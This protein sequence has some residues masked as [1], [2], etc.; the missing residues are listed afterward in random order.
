MMRLMVNQMY[1][2]SESSAR[3]SSTVRKTG[4]DA[5]RTNDPARVN[6]AGVWLMTLA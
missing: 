4:Y 2:A 3:A 5:R 1:L 6:G